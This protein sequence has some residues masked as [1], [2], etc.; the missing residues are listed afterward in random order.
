[1]L[2]NAQRDLKYS[3]QTKIRD[4]FYKA[5]CRLQKSE[6]KTLYLLL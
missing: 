3:N 6:I 4:N 5:R 1:V 2:I